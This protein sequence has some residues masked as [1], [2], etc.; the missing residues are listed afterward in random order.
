MSK[1]RRV[2]GESPDEE[3]KDQSIAQTNEIEEYV[4]VCDGIPAETKQSELRLFLFR[5]VELQNMW[6]EDKNETRQALIY[7][8][9]VEEMKKLID[10]KKIPLFKSS[11]L[12]FEKVSDELKSMSSIYF[13]LIS[14]KSIE[15][16]ENMPMLLRLLQIISQKRS[17]Q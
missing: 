6:M 17:Q 5:I 2:E 12:T 16:Q 13:H 4:V 11:P 9:T 15:D 14:G 7:F 1:Q 8:S 3:E 10:N